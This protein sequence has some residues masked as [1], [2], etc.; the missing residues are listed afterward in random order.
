[1]QKELKEKHPALA[2][3]QPHPLGQSIRDDHERQQSVID[4]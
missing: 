4:K 3:R 2:A 1:M